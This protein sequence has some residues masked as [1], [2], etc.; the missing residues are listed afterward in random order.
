MIEDEEPLR[1]LVCFH[2]DLAGFECT[3]AGDG[4]EGLRLATEEAFDLMVL[5][6]VLPGVDGVTLCRVVRREGCNR[7]VPIMMLTARLEEAD[8]VL[9]LESGADDY[10]TKPFG[11]RE[12]LARAGAL[13]RRPRSTWRANVDGTLQAAISLLGVTVDPSRRR[14]VCD[15]KVVALTPQEFSLLYVLVSNPGIVLSRDEL[16]ARVWDTD[17]FVTDRGVDT[18]VKRLRRKVEHDPTQ[19]RRIIT[20]WG[21][22]YKFGEL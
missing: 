2:L 22:G 8:K 18:L 21:A 4:K 9:G 5:D 13:M 19:P 14:V 11:V 16:L 17:V 12:L 6:V 1:D 15:G 10:V 3:A 20:V 7:D